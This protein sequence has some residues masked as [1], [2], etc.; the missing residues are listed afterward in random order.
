M[1]ILY[2]KALFTWRV[3]Y[4]PKRATL[5]YCLSRFRLHAMSG[6]VGGGFRLS[7]HCRVRAITDP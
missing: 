7:D 2:S 1:T 6:E 3:G 4:P 5:L